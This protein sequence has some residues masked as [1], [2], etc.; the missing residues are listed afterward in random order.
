M[1][2]KEGTR[3]RL[4]SSGR[5]TCEESGIL[6]RYLGT[7][8]AKRHKVNALY[9][10]CYANDNTGPYIPATSEYWEE[11]QL[12]NTIGGRLNAKGRR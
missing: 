8:T 7:R 1:H 6:D 12:C 5:E 11:V 4:N 10:V 3:L 2:Y 9:N